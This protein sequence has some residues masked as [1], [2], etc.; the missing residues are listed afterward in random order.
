MDA[1]AV[2]RMLASYNQCKA[3]AAHLK[4]SIAIMEQRLSEGASAAMIGE[5]LHA[6]NYDPMPHGNMPGDPVGT[7]VQRYVDGFIP[8]SLE[9]L[10]KEIDKARRDLVNAQAIIDFVDG[11]LLALTEREKFVIIH[12]VIDKETW[13]EVLSEYEAR[14]GPYGKQGLRFLRNRALDKI[15]MTVE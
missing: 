2:D 8:D 6:Q 5:A 12:Q 13:R 7:L 10:R 11:W 1:N 14:F 3:R 15:Y 4:T 9:E